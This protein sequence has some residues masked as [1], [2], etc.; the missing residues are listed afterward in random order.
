MLCLS[1]LRLVRRSCAALTVLFSTIAVL[2]SA[3]AQQSA[4]TVPGPEGIRTSYTSAPEPL[5]VPAASRHCSTI[6]PRP[7]GSFAEDAKPRDSP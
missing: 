6:P 7:P 2:P 3:S 4:P 5:T 1:N